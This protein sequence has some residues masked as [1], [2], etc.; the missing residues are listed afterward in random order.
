MTKQ[1]LQNNLT[2]LL[3]IFLSFSCQKNEPKHPEDNSEKVRS[4]VNIELN[5]LKSNADK[6]EYLEFIY[7]TDQGIRSEIYKDLVWIYGE[8]SK[9]KT[10]HSLLMNSLDDLNYV[11]I[12]NYLERFGHPEKEN[13]SDKAVNAAWVVIHHTTDLSKRKKHLQTLYQAYQK[14]NLSA[15]RLDLYLRRT[16]NAAFGNFPTSEGS[17]QIEDAIEKMMRELSAN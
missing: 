7:D 8:N 6:N 9:E 10:Y 11:R 5:R 4:A 1:Q 16:Y 15:D 17:Y 13:F 2:F 12:E 14:E 3:L